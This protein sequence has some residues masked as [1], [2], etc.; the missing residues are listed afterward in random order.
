MASISAAR[1][2]RV[3]EGPDR[4]VGGDGAVSSWCGR[5]WRGGPIGLGAPIRTFRL[6]EPLTGRLVGP[7]D[8][9]PAKV[10][11]VAFLSNRCP[12][13]RRLAGALGELTRE[14]APATLRTLAVNSIDGESIPEEG[15]AAIA[16]EAVRRGYDFPYLDDPTQE[17]ARAFGVSCTPDFFVF[18]ADR[19]LTY[20]GRFDA[21]SLAGLRR[22]H[23]AELRRA[24]RRTAG[25]RLPTTEQHPPEGCPIR[26]RSP[27]DA[28]SFAPAEASKVD[29]QLSARR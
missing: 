19:R 27:S 25:G 13:V 15:A 14:F 8:L 7:D 10:L 4:R 6:R 1:A 9:A 2:K 11:L 16:A 20:H 17:V 28:L 12:A 26:W 21:T 22:A 18:S 29:L 24:I 23:G 5:D 3:G